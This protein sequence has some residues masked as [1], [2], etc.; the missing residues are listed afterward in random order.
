M[1]LDHFFSKFFYLRTARMEMDCNLKELAHIQSSSY[2]PVFR[3]NSLK[4]LLPR[5]RKKILII[6]ARGRALCCPSRLANE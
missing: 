6:S 3:K 5:F 2:R 1:I 4:L